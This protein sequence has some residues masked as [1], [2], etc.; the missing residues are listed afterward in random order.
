MTTVHRFLVRASQVSLLALV[1]ATAACSSTQVVRPVT[2]AQ[3]IAY[4]GG[5]QT[6]GIISLDAT[7]AIIS[8]AKRAYY[9]SLL[10]IYGD[11][12]W[13]KGGLPIFPVALKQDHG[14]TPAGENFHVTNAAL[15]QLT[16]MHQWFKMGRTP[17]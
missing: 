5:Q 17:Q 4:D 11:A 16:Q 2:P 7:G 12:R 15:V 9:N 1:L 14:M 6:A 8:P 3:V 13:T 10:A